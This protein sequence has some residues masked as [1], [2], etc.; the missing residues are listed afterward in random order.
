MAKVHQSKW[1]RDFDKQN[2]RR[3]KPVRLSRGSCRRLPVCY[4]DVL[5]GDIGRAL[6]PSKAQK[7]QYA[8]EDAAKKAA[9]AMTP[10]Q[11][12]AAALKFQQD[13]AKLTGQ[14]SA[15]VKVP[16]QATSAIKVTAAQLAAQN[17]VIKQ[18]QA[19]QLAAQAEAT[20]DANA[21][22]AAAQAQAV[23]DAAAQKANAQVAAL[24]QEQA[25][26]LAQKL[27]QQQAL[28][29]QMAINKPS[30]QTQ[31]A[32][33]IAAA[34]NSAVQSIIKDPNET[35]EAYKIAGKVWAPGTKSHGM[36]IGMPGD[37]GSLRPVGGPIGW[38]VTLV[39][40][41]ATSPP[42]ERWWK[43]YPDGTEESGLG[44]PGTF[45]FDKS[46]NLLKKLQSTASFDQAA[47]DAQQAALT[48]SQAGFGTQAPIVQ[49]DVSYN[50]FATAQASV[51]TMTPENKK[52]LM[53]GAAAVG[54]LLLVF[55]LTRKKKSP[56]PYY[57]PP[58]QQQTYPPRY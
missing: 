43:K 32:A 48:A 12:Q 33:V 30:V 3:T 58:Q 50:P 44:T 17:A 51:K 54:G 35:P 8:R 7:A 23:A 15:A 19:A 47:Y 37:A 1:M 11:Q 41:T 20:G 55:V 6:F 53:I 46:G 21:K 2:K 28:S 27:A 25:V 45:S 36:P 13:F 40:G 16:G 49:T 42:M 5:L 22:L 34:A 9:A 10:A 31:N 56:Q 26:K 4:D 38:G 24:K 52:M 14:V 57:P 29:A 18:Q 39:E